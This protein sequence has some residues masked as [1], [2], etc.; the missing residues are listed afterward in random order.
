MKTVIS[1]SRMF[2]VYFMPMVASFVFTCMPMVGDFGLQ[3]DLIH[4][5]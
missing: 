2:I 1:L 5:K 4:P 3:M